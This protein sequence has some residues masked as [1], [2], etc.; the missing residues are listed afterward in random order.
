[1][2]SRLNSDIA[3]EYGERGKKPRCRTNDNR[4]GD[5]MPTRKHQPGLNAAAPLSHDRRD[6]FQLVMD[7]MAIR[8]T[9]GDEAA[10]AGYVI[11]TLRAAGAP[12]SAI[13]ID[14]AHRRTPVNGD[15]GNLVLRLPGS[16]RAPRRMLSAHL[17]TVPIC[18][19]SQPVRRNGHVVSA[20]PATGLGADDRAGVAAILT[21]AREIIRHRLPHPPLTFCWFV[22]EEIG[23]HGARHVRR[24]M[25][26]KP[27][28]AFNWDGGNAN[29]LTIGAT[30]GYRIVVEIEGLAS[31]AGGAPERGVSAIAIAAL[32]IADLQDNGWHGQIRKN[33]KQGTSNVGVIRGGDATNVVTDHVLVRAEARSHDRQFRRT[34][35]KEIK[36]A[37]ERALGK[38]ISADG[39]RGRMN[40]TG[41]LDYDSF[42][43]K[44]SEPCVQVAQAAVRSLGLEPELA[45][46]N[47]GLDANWTTKHGIPTVSLGCGQR[48][49]HTVNE[50]LDIEQFQTACQVALTLATGTEE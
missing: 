19:G 47:G 20:D 39:K 36:Q 26:A 21:A 28:L 24:S 38:I 27:Q 48:N 30:G 49:A 3:L 18:V 16:S 6:A 50:Q 22:Q 23:L 45:I 9:S 31:H 25:L 34:I 7:L 13:H 11:D 10:A 32:A 4:R 46:A 35:V 37:F 41:Q 29:K 15:H 5:R 12:A 44:T 43:L 14:A 1:M 17:D 40:W 8:G 42:Q 2:D 33:G